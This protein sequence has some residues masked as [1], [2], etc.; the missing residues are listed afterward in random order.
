ESMNVYGQWPWPRTV[1]AELISRLYE[2]QAV[3]IAFDV[4]FAEPDRT[5]PA[6]VVKHFRNLDEATREVLG[7]LPSNDKIFAE[8]IARGKVV[9]GQSG[10]GS[11]T[12][13]LEKFPETGFAT[14]GPDPRPYLVGFPHLLRNIPELEQ[15]AAG[16]GLFSIR[17]ERDGI[18]R[19]VP[20]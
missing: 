4:V 16:R 8:V 11:G 14:I 9:V 17:P 20:I 2:M 13:P 7:Q 12:P 19:R 3:A 15:S 5:S 1:L 6:E 18:I 10:A